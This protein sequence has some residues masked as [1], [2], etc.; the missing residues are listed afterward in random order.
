MNNDRWPFYEITS[1]VILSLYLGGC[2]RLSRT[3]C[4]DS[5]SPLSVAKHHA[6]GSHQRS[7]MTSETLKHGC[8]TCGRRGKRG[9]L[10]FF[11]LSL[12]WGERWLFVCR[13]RDLSAR[14]P[15]S[16]SHQPLCHLETKLMSIRS[17]DCLSPCVEY[18]RSLIETC[19]QR[20]LRL[21]KLTDGYKKQWNSKGYS[22]SHSPRG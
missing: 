5:S 18:V 7:R 6:R 14:V 21:Y 17:F 1:P 11:F 2:Y 4:L 22:N 13:Q 19:R 15:A 10:W 8:A 16:Y 9:Y 3:V 20:K 12:G